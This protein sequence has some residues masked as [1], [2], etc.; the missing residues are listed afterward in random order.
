MKLYS[1][2]ESPILSGIVYRYSP[3]KSFL[4]SLLFILVSAFCFISAYRGGFMKFGEDVPDFV[5]YPMGFIF[6]IAFLITFSRFRKAL[7]PENWVLK[8]GMD[9]ILV[10]YRSY[11][12]CHLPDKDPIIT[13]ISFSEIA[14]ARKTKETVYTENSDSTQTRFYT[15]LDIKLS[16]ANTEELKNAL[17]FERNRKPPIESLNHDLFLAR[18]H[19]K[20]KHEIDELIEKVRLEKLKHPDG[21]KRINGVSNHHLVRWTDQDILRIEWN[22]LCPSINQAVDALKTKVTVESEIKIESDYTS[23]KSDKNLDDQI[24]D[25]AERGKKME[26]ITLVR[27]KYGYSLTEAKEFVEN[28]FK[29]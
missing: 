11:L 5:Q 20:P 25:L 14:W 6:A 26:A 10:K 1:I 24:L 29:K 12:N 9:R 16:T 4:F 17:K 2:R 19:K 27:M 13:E 18:K 28:L 22:G 21:G 8:L 15:F 7:R 23:N 3:L